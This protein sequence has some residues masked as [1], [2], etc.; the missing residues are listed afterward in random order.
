MTHK[1]H[2]NWGI[3]QAPGMSLVIVLLSL[4]VFS[5][6]QDAARHCVQGTDSVVI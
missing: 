1:S 3:H 2:Y 5:V 4:L 6:I